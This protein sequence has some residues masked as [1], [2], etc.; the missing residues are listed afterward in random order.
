[1]SD[2]QRRMVEGA[3]AVLRAPGGADGAPGA[4]DGAGADGGGARGA[5]QAAMP[6]TCAWVVLHL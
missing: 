4:G 1:M 5:C 2:Q 3:L 6:P